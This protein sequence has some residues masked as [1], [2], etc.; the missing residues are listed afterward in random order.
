MIR[1]LDLALVVVKDN[2]HV[3]EVSFWCLS[4]KIRVCD[5]VSLKYLRRTYDLHYSFSESE[6]RSVFSEFAFWFLQTLG[7]RCDYC[8]PNL[9]FKR[10][11]SFTTN[12]LCCSRHE[13]DSIYA[14]VSS[15]KHHA[16][17][18]AASTNKSQSSERSCPSHVRPKACAESSAT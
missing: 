2:F 10:I 12:F 3:R 14:C 6:F 13:L 15:C 18:I 16:E 5:P 17:E 1:V 9:P 7:I 8:L 4:D 11:L